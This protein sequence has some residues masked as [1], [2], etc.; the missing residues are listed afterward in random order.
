MESYRCTNL[1][2]IY[3]LAWGGTVACMKAGIDPLD[4][5]RKFN[6]HSRGPL[7]DILLF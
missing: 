6:D 5:G 3:N 7:P 2:Y 4:N 1:L